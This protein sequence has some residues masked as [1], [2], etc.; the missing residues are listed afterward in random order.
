MALR[1]GYYGIKRWLYDQLQSAPAKLVNI[2]ENINDAGVRNFNAS[3][4]NPTTQNGIVWSFDDNGVFEANGTAT[5]TTQRGTTFPAQF[6]SQMVVSGC[7]SKDS[8]VHIY[9]YD[10][11]DNARPYKDSSKTERM[12]ST[13]NVYDDKEFSFYM[14]KGHT[15]T[16]NCRVTNGGVANHQKF[17]PMLRLASD[18]N[19]SYVPYA[20]TNYQLTGSA[21]DQKTAINAIISAATGAADFAAFKTAMAAITPVT[22]SAAPAERSLDVEEDEPVVKKTTRKKTTKTEEEE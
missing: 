15:Y 5:G 7:S 3:V 14:I 19:N 11:T 13:D 20:Q 2:F 18:P 17:Y 1:A 22:R 9:I 16:V 6:T 21:N 10:E 8:K 4:Y 12:A